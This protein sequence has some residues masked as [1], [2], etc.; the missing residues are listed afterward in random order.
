VLQAAFSDC[1]FLDLLSHLQDL[2][3]SSVI[4]VGGRQIVQALVVTMVVVVVDESADLA[5]QIAGQEVVFQE[6]PVFHG[7]MPP[8]DLALGLG[9]M[10]RT[11]NVIHAF[12]LKIVCEI[13]CHIGRA[14]V[15][16]QPG[17]IHDLGLIAARGF[18]RQIQRVSDILGFHRCAKLPS[19]DVAAVVIKDCG[20]VEPAPADD[21]QVGKVSLPEFVRPGSLV[22]EL[23]GRADHHMGRRRDQVFGLEKAIC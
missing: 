13:G 21:L 20:Q 5:F 10:W 2:C 14:V 8:F 4:D 12:V 6:N 16:K 22:A 11:T 23:I 18:Q 1:L 7:L 19:N 17:L 15:A 9:V 3:A